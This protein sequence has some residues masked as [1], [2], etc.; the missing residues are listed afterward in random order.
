[1]A[2]VL[3]ATPSVLLVV[4]KGEL[5]GAQTHV[6]GLCQAL[7][8]GERFAL[9]IGGD[10]AAD[11]PLGTAAS[12]LGVRVH[13]LPALANSLSPWQ[14]LLAVREL[15]RLVRRE[16]PAM[17]HAHSAVAG[18]VARLAG[19]LARRPVVYTVHGFGFK[20]QAPAL[21]RHLAHAAEWTL[22]P[23]TTHMV[24]VSDHERALARR[25]PIAPARVSVVHNTVPDSAARAHPAAEPMR[26]VMVARAAA[27]KR[28]D[29]LLQALALARL[30]AGHEMEVSFIGGG[31]DLHRLV[32]LS[33]QL[34][35]RRAAFAGDVHDVEHRLA[36]HQ[37][38]VL[39]SDHEGLPVCVIEAMRAGLA[40]VASDLPGIRELVVDGTHALLVPNRAEA[41]ADA[42]LRLQ[43]APCMRARLG[44]AARHRYE[45]QFTP[46]HTAAA[47]RHLY[48]QIAGHGP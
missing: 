6:L 19:L 9:A 43:A 35:L 46:A 8:G 38:F 33:Q 11:S 31:P 25:L 44:Q 12:R 13:A 20:A 24:C 15:L 47:M 40:I 14:V 42:L 32:Q 10:D 34:S 27:P 29:L 21:Q 16:R 1:M 17:L 30:R 23:A 7:G 41:L 26:V 28:H 3:G 18:M 45:A 37:V 4:T 22:A 48:G 39:V 36:Q 2:G 5:G